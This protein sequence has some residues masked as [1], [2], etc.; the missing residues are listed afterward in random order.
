MCVTAAYQ[1]LYASLQTPKNIGY[2][3]PLPLTDV[4]DAHFIACSAPLQY[5]FVFICC[6]FCFPVF[7][8]Q[9]VSAE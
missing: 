4:L 8:M 5:A 2:T 1:S 7:V 3:R 9:H 6:C